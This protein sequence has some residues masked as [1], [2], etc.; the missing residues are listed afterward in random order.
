MNTETIRYILISVIKILLVI[1]G[2]IFLFIIGTAI[3]YGLIGNGNT[4]DVF[5]G[6][7]WQHIFSFF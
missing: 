1:L 4:A 7:I 3:G 6:E 2:M 5:D